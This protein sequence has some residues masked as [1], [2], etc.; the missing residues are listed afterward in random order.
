MASKPE[1]KT[2]IEM[3]KKCSSY[4]GAILEFFINMETEMEL[5]IANYFT[6]NNDKKAMEFIHVLLMQE[7]FNFH[8]KRRMIIFIM[9]NSFLEFDKKHKKLDSELQA[10]NA[11]RNK[12]CHHKLHESYEQINKFDDNTLTSRPLKSYF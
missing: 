3:R 7:G 5:L 11:F 8:N 2:E 6:S 1:N 9:K 10:L 4:R 12:V